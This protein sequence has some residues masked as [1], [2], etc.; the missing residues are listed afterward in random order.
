MACRKSFSGEYFMNSNLNKCGEG[1]RKT[2][3]L[4]TFISSNCFGF[5]YCS[6]HSRLQFIVR[7]AL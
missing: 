7:I 1:E 2:E 5:K 4:F 3:G 6:C